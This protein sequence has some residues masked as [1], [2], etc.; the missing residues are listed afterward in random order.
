M[1][2]WPE[3]PGQH[4]LSILRV[5]FY[6]I[7]PAGVH[8]GMFSVAWQF[9]QLLQSLSHWLLRFCSE[10]TDVIIQDLNPEY[11][12]CLII[13]RNKHRPCRLHRVPGPLLSDPSFR[14]SSPQLRIC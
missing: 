13:I 11:P 1:R 10:M 4:E 6:N 2:K 5:R 14:I 8:L 7:S 12:T 9:R 3:R